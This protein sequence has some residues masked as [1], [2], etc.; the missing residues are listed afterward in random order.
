MKRRTIAYFK[1]MKARKVFQNPLK[2]DL[3]TFLAA[4]MNLC[5]SNV[6]KQHIQ[7]SLQQLQRP[8]WY[9]LTA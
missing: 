3:N 8:D 1:Q 7:E 4:T 9:K 6:V 2:A 5:K